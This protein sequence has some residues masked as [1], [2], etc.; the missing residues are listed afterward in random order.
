MRKLFA[1][2]VCLA[3]VMIFTQRAQC[4]REGMTGDDRAQKPSPAR[5]ATAPAE[6]STSQ[7]PPPG[8]PLSA[9]T[10]HADQ[11]D[12]PS[13]P[14]GTGIKMKLETAIST[15]TSKAG[16]IFSGRV[17]EPVM[18]DGKTVIPVGAALEGHV[19]RVTEP[20]RIKGVPSIDLRP[21]LVTLPNGQT[22]TINAVVVDTDKRGEN[23]VTDEGRIKGRGHTAKD[24]RE[25]LIGTGAGAGVGAL[26]GGGQGVIIGAGVGATATITHWLTKRHSAF[27]SPGT[28]IVMEL[29]RPMMLT[30]NKPGI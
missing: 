24:T 27:L 6:R 13:L 9:T 22:Y 18:L 21:E 25:V 3:M 14:S 1:F 20:R 2:V 8:P 12:G 11:A 23:S 10:P 29:S 28:E 4:E 15:R 17:T 16:D 30:E 26:L 5:M 7:T 19:V